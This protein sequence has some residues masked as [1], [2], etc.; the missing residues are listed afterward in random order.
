MSFLTGMGF[1]VLGG[2]IRVGVDCT[3]FAILSKKEEKTGLIFFILTSIIIG[4]FLGIVLDY[5]WA[6]SFLAGY[7]ALD[8]LDGLYKTAKK[9]K[10]KL[11]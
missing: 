10:I 2:L 9:V 7:T 4:A 1:G 11:T 8:V 5:G 3:K 6:L